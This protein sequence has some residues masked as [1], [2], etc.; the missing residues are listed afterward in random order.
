[1]EGK[2]IIGVSDI[3][4]IGSDL[5]I[6]IP[7]F[8]DTLISLLV[9][10]VMDGNL[11]LGALC[12]AS[13]T[14]EP[15]AEFRAKF[16]AALLHG[17]RAESESR[18]AGVWT[19]AGVDLKTF[20]T[21]DK[22]TQDIESFYRDN[23][24]EFL[25]NSQPSSAAADQSSKAAFDVP[26]FCKELQER[27]KADTSNILNFVTDRVKD[28]H[29]PDFVRGLVTTL[30]E[31]CIDGLGGPVDKIKLNE[32][33]F[34]NLCMDILTELE[35]TTE[36]EIQC[37]LSIQLLATKLEHP[38]DLFLGLLNQLY[39]SDVVKYPATKAWK[40]DSKADN[41]SGKGVCVAS[42]SHLL[43]EIAEAEAD[44]GADNDEEDAA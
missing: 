27:L 18:V 34:S 26:A 33:A 9:A 6:D 28:R 29:S 40:D 15:R 19:Q 7:K 39:Q 36:Q 30:A 14:K 25:Q 17:M 32:E 42:S 41:L 21:D 20:L 5:E 35:F 23:K 24:L 22:G 13:R 4:E 44:E 2:F 10:P 1:M 16:L 3:L 8:W 31:A 43:V 12:E 11:S 38:V 37:I